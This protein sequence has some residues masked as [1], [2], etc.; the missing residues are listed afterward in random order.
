[1]VDLEHV[2]LRLRQG[3]EH[4]YDEPYLFRENGEDYPM[5]AID[6]AHRA[7]HG[8][9]ADLCDRRGIKQALRADGLDEDDETR[10][11]I[12]AMMAEIIR[13]ADR[14]RFIA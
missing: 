14:D 5:L 2:R 1:M 9:L 6:W 11:E 10:A 13:E 3:A 7:A 8:I 4:P 12:V